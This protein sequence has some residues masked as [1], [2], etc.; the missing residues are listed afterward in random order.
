MV[1]VLAGGLMMFM[2]ALRA[3]VQMTGNAQ[4]TQLR[5]TN[6]VCLRP[7]GPLT[8]KPFPPIVLLETNMEKAEAVRL[9]D[10]ENNLWPATFVYL[11]GGNLQ[12]II[13][14][15]KPAALACP[16]VTNG[17]YG[18]MQVIIVDSRS[19]FINTIRRQDVCQLLHRIPA[20]VLRENKLFNNAVNELKVFEDCES[21]QNW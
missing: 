18:D 19:T 11:K 20:H 4:K 2:L 3:Q 12:E 17:A 14:Q 13:E 7:A 1:S 6:L 16:T 8:S 21:A 5:A 10:L 9:S 15:I